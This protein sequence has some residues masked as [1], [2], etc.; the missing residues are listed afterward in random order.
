MPSKIVA[1]VTARKP[2]FS[3]VRTATF[4]LTENGCV[5]LHSG[6]GG[7]VISCRDEDGSLRDFSSSAPDDC[8]AALCAAVTGEG[9]QVVAS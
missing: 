1:A 9:W 7:G 8:L 6:R 2:T 5:I 4:Q 3:G